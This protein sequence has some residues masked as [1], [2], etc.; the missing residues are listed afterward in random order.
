M[1]LM[2]FQWIHKCL[3]APCHDGACQLVYDNPEK[4]REIE[5]YYRKM[6]GKCPNDL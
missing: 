5:S 3:T 2:I 1:L 4:A 6:A